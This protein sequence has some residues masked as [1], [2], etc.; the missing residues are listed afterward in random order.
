MA[1]MPSF[2]HIQ[3]TGRPLIVCD[4]DEVVLEF[5]TPFQ[6]FLRSQ[7]HDLLPRSFRLHGNVVLGKTGEPVAE[8]DMK[9]LLE[10]FFL[11]QDAWQIPAPRAVETLEALSREADL[12]FLTAMPPRHTHIRRALL[13]RHELLYPLL[14]TEGPKGPVIRHLISK[15][16]VPTVFLDDIARNLQSV[17]EHV[18]DCLLINLM[19][20]DDF[21]LMAPPP[22]D[23]ILVVESWGEAETLIR[24]H[25]SGNPKP[26]GT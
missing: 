21:R 16:P 1:G 26:A 15:A 23:G 11:A 2:D 24:K 14:A 3:L 10:A 6:N 22:G 25:L 13:D 5:I 18:P 19:V 17:R 4:I 20:N 7:A 8:S 12:I 9:A